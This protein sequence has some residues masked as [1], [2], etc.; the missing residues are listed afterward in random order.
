MNKMNTLIIACL[1]WMGLICFSKTANA[2]DVKPY[3]QEDLTMLSLEELLNI[4]VTSAS[5]KEETVFAAPSIVATITAEEIALF[6]G[7]DLLDVLERATSIYNLSSM[8]FRKSTVG[9]RGDLPDEVNTHLLF[10]IDGRPFRDSNKA[11][12]NTALLSA[13]PL[14]SIKQIEI[15]RGPGSVIHGTNAYVGVVN[16]ITKKDVDYLATQVKGGSFGTIKAEANGGKTFGDLR[17]SGGINFRSTEGWNFRDS[18]FSMN[19]APNRKEAAVD[20]AEQAIGAN[21]N[22]A[23]KHFTLKGFVG[24]NEMTNVVGWHE[25]DAFPYRAKR[26]WFDLGWQDTLL[27]DKY[28]LSLNITSNSTRDEFEMNN[29]VTMGEV[30]EVYADDYLFEFTNFYR[31]FYQLELTFGG[32]VNLLS[33]SEEITVNDN[34]RYISVESY[35]REW[36]RGY[37]QAD[38]KTTDWL[39][40]VLGGQLNKVPNV[41][42]NF[43]PRLALIAN[44]RSGFGGKILYGQAFRSP[45]AA[46]NG[47]IGPVIVDPRPVFGNNRLT[48]EVISTFEAQIFYHLKK[49]TLAVNYF[50]SKQT[51]LIKRAPA[52]SN[53]GELESQGIEAEWKLT[54]N[55]NLFVIGSYTYQLSENQEGE[56]DLNG[57]PRHMFKL[58]LSYNFDQWVNLAFHHAYY[59]SP[60]EK[61]AIPNVG[62]LSDYHLA[63]LKTSFNLSQITR[64]TTNLQLFA[65]VHNLWDSKVYNPSFLIGTDRNIIRTQPG[66]A[67]YLGATITF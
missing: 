16:I 15:I 47:L 62:L 55:K 63:T 52:Y 8:S 58:G 42:L 17:I 48:P 19:I 14:G 59:S 24:A 10:M 54:P 35:N 21:L 12:L 43:A 37:V 41:N 36:F 46:E 30:N 13:F 11:G 2:Q 29:P 28:A 65:E 40:I 34:R 1:V 23:Y 56:Q 25:N 31:P 61:G 60:I 18:V 64:G 66:R 50:L 7:N 39:T 38:L 26:L 20:L 67:V 51:D 27:V 53:A 45:N 32:T 49:S 4:S 5:K 57:L 33:G 44:N 22:L 6:G 3:D 9:L